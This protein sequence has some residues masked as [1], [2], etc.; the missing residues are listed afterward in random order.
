MVLAAALLAALP[1]TGYAGLS[2]DEAI[3]RQRAMRGAGPG[4]H[5]ADTPLV[6]DPAEP[7]GL[8]AALGGPGNDAPP[9]LRP[10]LG[11][12]GGARMRLGTTM[13]AGEVR[14]QLGAA[15][16]AGD[17]HPFTL[18]GTS[19]SAPL[20][21]GRVY[22][23]VE[24]RHWG[25]SWTG[26]LILDAAA[27]P[28]P[29]IGWRKDDDGR[30]VSAPFSWL[31]PWR[32]DVFIGE[33]DQ[34]SG[35]RHARLI[36]A[37]F[38][39]MPVDG[40]ELAASRTMQ[41][42][43]SGRPQSVQSLARAL[44]GRD[45][46]EEGGSADEPGNQL[47]GFDARYTFRWGEGRS[48]SIYGQAI[49][50]DEADNLPSHYLGSVGIDAA[51]PVAGGSARLFL[52]HANTA[53]DGFGSP[54]LGGAYRHHIYTDGYTQLGD[55]LGHPAAGDVRLTSAGVFVDRGPWTGAFMLHRGS[56]Y[57][58]SQLYPG[59]GRLAGANAEV[60]WQVTPESRL[61]LALTWWRDPIETRTRVQLWWQLAF[62]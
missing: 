52:E 60:A 13:A 1:D 4:I 45:N 26:S 40:L 2:L 61:G 59:G 55:P 28:V 27:R 36:G 25:P 44:L 8:T 58:T 10:V 22:A 5:I 15:W 24:R 14:A 6:L 62:R 33:L 12:D 29:S 35:P 11:G 17:D 23:S 39:F 19:I 9:F 46:V 47:A 56:A 43:G 41:W 21:A 54:I 37:R 50:E 32:T 16:R 3:A 18:D 57:A 38:Q 51:V 20:G 34:R 48:V 42:G 31:G 53:V 30:F 49:G 7:E